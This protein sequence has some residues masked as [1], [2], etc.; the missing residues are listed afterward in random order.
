MKRR[1]FLKRALGLGVAAAVTGRVGENLLAEETARLRREECKNDVRAMKHVE[2]D[3]QRSEPS[4]FYAE[5]KLEMHGTCE[6]EI[7]WAEKKKVLDD[8][9]IEVYEN[10]PSPLMLHPESF[11]PVVACSGTI[12]GSGWSPGDFDDRYVPMPRGTEE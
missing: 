7:E 9:D 8:L 1:G 10:I 12:T 3:E 5:E 6:Q 4:I 11:A 2:R